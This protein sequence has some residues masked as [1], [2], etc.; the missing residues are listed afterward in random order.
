MKSKKNELT[1]AVS[2]NFTIEVVQQCDE[3]DATQSIWWWTSNDKLDRQLDTEATRA[4][5]H[6]ND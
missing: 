1:L 2:L 6:V 5:K 3:I 4:L